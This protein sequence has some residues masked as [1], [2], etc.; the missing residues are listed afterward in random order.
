MIRRSFS[1]LNHEN[2][3][4]RELNYLYEYYDADRNDILRKLYREDMSAYID[5]AISKLPPKCRE[6]FLLS[7]VEGLSNK[8]ISARLNLS[9]S[10]VENHVH[11]ALLRLRNMLRNLNG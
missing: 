11:N 2:W 9:L 6:V 1:R 10:T 7:Y 4:N 3:L 8:E 5:N